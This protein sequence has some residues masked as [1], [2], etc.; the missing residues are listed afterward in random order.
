MLFQTEFL[1]SLALVPEELAAVQSV[2]KKISSES[3][4][5][6]APED[7]QKFAAYVAQTYMRGMKDPE[8]LAAFCETA[9]KARFSVP[10]DV[11]DLSAS[12]TEPW[13]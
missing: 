1:R 6:R 10:E 11:S 8:K 9:A 4:F 3:W 12:R 13:Q 7:Q 2:F 5:S